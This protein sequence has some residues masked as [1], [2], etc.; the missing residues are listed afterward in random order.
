MIVDRWCSSAEPQE[1]IAVLDLVELLPTADACRVLERLLGDPAPKV[2]ELAA[3]HVEDAVQDPEDALAMIDRALEHEQHR[4][5]VAELGGRR[6]TC[7]RG[8][9]EPPESGGYLSRGTSPTAFATLSAY[10]PLVGQG[11]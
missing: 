6:R 4:D 10:P 5:V 1:R 7:S 8:P 11:S 9:S 2:R 3:L